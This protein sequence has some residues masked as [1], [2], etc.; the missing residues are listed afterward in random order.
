MSKAP[1]TQPAVQLERR[2]MLSEANPFTLMIEVE[3]LILAGYRLE[4]G[5]D[6]TMVPWLLHRLPGTA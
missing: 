3:R 6:F 1:K 5:A 2:V 4:L